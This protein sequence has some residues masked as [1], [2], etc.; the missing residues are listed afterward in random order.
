MGISQ[1]AVEEEGER[2]GLPAGVSTLQRT[3]SGEFSTLTG[4]FFS[5]F[6][7]FLCLGH[8]DSAQGLLLAGSGYI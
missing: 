2:V 1:K 5:F 7:L 4:R 6:F 8:T 3:L